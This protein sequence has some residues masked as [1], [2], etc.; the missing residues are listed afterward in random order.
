M[1]DGIKRSTICWQ[2]DSW[3][4]TFFPLQIYLY[5]LKTSNK[6]KKRISRFCLVINKKTSSPS[7]KQE[8]EEGKNDER[9]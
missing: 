8:E 9:M 3:N 5:I 2:L 6:M 7:G 1:F 4:F